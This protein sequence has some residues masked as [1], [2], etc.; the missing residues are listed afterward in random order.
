MGR[1]FRGESHHKVDAKGRVSIPA[2]FRRVLEAG[3]PNWQS[4]APD[5][6]SSKAPYRIYNIGCNQPV[7]LLHFIDVLEQCIGKKAKKNMLPIQPGDVPDTYA[8]VSDLIADVGY[9]P[10]VSVEKGVSSFVDWY[11]TYYNP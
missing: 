9:K 11:R 3:D 8:D 1:R 4:D 7:E 5:P 6:G 2:S 10:G